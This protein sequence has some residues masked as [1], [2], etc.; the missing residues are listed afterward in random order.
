MEKQLRIL[1]LEDNPADVKLLQREL[2]KSGLVYECIVVD[3]RVEFLKM[4]IEFDPDIILSDHSLPGFNSLEA[5]Q[6]IKDGGYYIPFILVTGTVSE[7]F[8]VKC[9]LNGADDYILKG[10][11]IRL[12]A[13]IANC[14]SKK[15]ML[16]EKRLIESLHFKLQTAYTEIE[17]MHSDI[18]DS[19]SYAKRIQEAMLPEKSILEKFF[20]RAFIIYKPKDIISGD[21][22][23]F[24][25]V[26][27]MITVAVM[28]CTG[29]GVPGALMSMLGNNLLNEI[30]NVQRVTAP[31]EILKKLNIGVRKQLKQDIKG[32]KGQDGMDISICS[33]DKKNMTFQY[34]GAGQNL[35]YFKDKQFELIKGDRKTVGGYQAEVERSYTNHEISFRHGD[36]LFMCTD[37]YADQFGG[38]KDKRMQTKNLIKLIQSTLSLGFREQEK[39]LS[40]WLEK[41]QGRLK[42]TDDILLVGIEL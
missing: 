37:G 2:K 6:I 31:G 36:T 17:Q 12:P 1:L 24:N 10:N 39:L 23:W 4:I 25:E 27:G 21:F 5:L 34:A 11:L 13:A 9:M 38:R 16:H 41:W 40:E 19:I 35:F 32:A 14:I 20:P 29:H 7:D 30:I 8:A 33:V 18:T 42:Q 26:N 28:D 22:Y 3:S 15:E